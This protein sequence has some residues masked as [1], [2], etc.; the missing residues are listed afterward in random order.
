MLFGFQRPAPQAE[1]PALQPDEQSSKISF[2]CQYLF[3][4]PETFSAARSD[5]QT[6]GFQKGLA[7]YHK[8]FNSVKRKIYGKENKFPRRTHKSLNC[9]SAYEIYSSSLHTLPFKNLIKPMSSQLMYFHQICRT[10]CFNGNTHGNDN[11]ITV[12]ET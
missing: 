9:N 2:G 10:A 1:K 8:H 3:C 12:A 7:F 5:R 6:L 4:C 11:L